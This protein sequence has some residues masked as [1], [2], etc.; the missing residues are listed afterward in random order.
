L[1]YTSQGKLFP[2]CVD[3]PSEWFSYR[4]PGPADGLP[5]CRRLTYY[6]LISGSHDSANI[7]RE[8][9]GVLS[10]SKVLRHQKGYI[11]CCARARAILTFE[12]ILTVPIPYQQ[13]QRLKAHLL[14]QYRP[15]SLSYTNNTYTMDASQRRPS[16]FLTLSPVNYSEKAVASPPASPATKAAKV[17][18]T[19]PPVVKTQRS[20]SES[21]TSS[22]SSNASRFL[23]LGHVDIAEE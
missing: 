6:R 18:A 19:I 12:Q 13:R 15:F 4:L 9:Q 21:S 7:D 22:T 1:R 20:A 2:G 23:R 14:N 5:K 17:D 11:T 3:H 10:T 16:T 8:I